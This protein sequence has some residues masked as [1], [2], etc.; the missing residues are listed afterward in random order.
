LGAG[1]AYLLMVAPSDPEDERQPI[2]GGELISL[3]SA[4][5]V[6]FRKLDDIRRRT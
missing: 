1:A 5:A 6:L 2:T 4:A 3:T